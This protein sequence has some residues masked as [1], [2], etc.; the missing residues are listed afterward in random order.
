MVAEAGFEPSLPHTT[1]FVK[2]DG[3]IEIGYDD[4]NRSFIR[5]VNGGGMVWEGQ[6]QY[7][8]VDAALQAL[9]MGLAAWYRD[10]LRAW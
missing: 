1:R 2:E 3:W 8:S 6:H 10:Q 9:E 7:P 4:W 5:A